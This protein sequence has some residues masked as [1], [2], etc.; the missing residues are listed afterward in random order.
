M[1]NLENLL[2]SKAEVRMPIDSF[3]R[4]WKKLLGIVIDGL[5]CNG[6]EVKELKGM[7]EL[8]FVYEKITDVGAL[9]R[10]G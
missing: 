4:E 8:V 3:L 2:N 10:K 7:E 6:Y 5:K 9:Y 1:G